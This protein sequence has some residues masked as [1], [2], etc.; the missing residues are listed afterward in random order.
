MTFQ[1]KANENFKNLSKNQQKKNYKTKK[2]QDHDGSSKKVDKK[3]RK[4]LAFF[5]KFGKRLITM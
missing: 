3:V 5:V 2:K 1:S 4:T